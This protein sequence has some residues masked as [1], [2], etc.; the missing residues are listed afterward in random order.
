M[1][2][3]EAGEPLVLDQP[4]RTTAL[5]PLAHRDDPLER[6]RALLERGHR[7]RGQGVSADRPDPF[8]RELD[9]R[10]DRVDRERM[11]PPGEDPEEVGPV[12]DPVVLWL[13]LGAERRGSIGVATVDPRPGRD[14]R[15]TVDRRGRVEAGEI[16]LRAR[17][18]QVGRVTIE[19][20]LPGKLRELSAEG[21]EVGV[22]LLAPPRPPIVEA[23]AQ[24]CRSGSIPPRRLR[25]SAGPRRLPSDGEAPKAKPVGS[26]PPADTISRSSNDSTFGRC[27]YRNSSSSTESCRSSSSFRASAIP[28][29]GR[30]STS[31][32]MTSA[33]RISM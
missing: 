18:Q 4:G 19:L 17:R 28:S 3:A 7:A 23:S 1:V 6:L 22:L 8:Q 30:Y 5:E 25:S 9:D 21:F 15:G 24:A 29:S 13:A 32:S 11:R 27:S 33:S 26:R 16:S 20:E 2:D 12:E 31:S 14:A 10:E